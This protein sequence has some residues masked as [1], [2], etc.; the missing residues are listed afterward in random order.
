VMAVAGLS[1]SWMRYYAFFVGNLTDPSLDKNLLRFAMIRSA[2]NPT[3]HLIAVALAYES[4]RLAIILYV[5]I[6]LLYF[7]PS[8][9][10]RHTLARTIHH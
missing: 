6:P 7:L 5:A 3:L 9:L 1:F 8:K 4:T 10:E 2:L